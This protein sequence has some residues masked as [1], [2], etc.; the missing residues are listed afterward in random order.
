MNLV[1]EHRAA[2]VVFIL[3]TLFIDS[4]GFGLVIP[5]LPKLVEQLVGG[6]ISEASFAVGLL[7]SLYAVMQFFAAPLLGALSDRFGRRPVILL[8]LTSLGVDYVLLSLAPNLWWLVAGRIIAGIGGATITPAG[9]YIADVSPPDQRASNFGLMGVAFGLGF[10]AG[11]ALGGV[12]GDGNLRLPFVVAAGLSLLNVLFGLVVLPE[13]LAPENRRPLVLAQTNPLGAL[14]A[15]WRNPGVAAVMSVAAATGVAQMGLKSVWVLY[16]TYR[17][18]WSVADVGISLA[19]IGLLSIVVQGALVRPAVGR[20][21]EARTLVSALLVTSAS[22]VV[23]GLATQGWMMYAAT[24]GYC[25]GVGL[26]GPAMQGLLSRAVPADEQGLLQ[27]AVASVNTPAA[28][29]GPLLATGLF[30]YFVAPTAPVALPGAPFFMGGVL[31]LVSLALAARV[32]AARTVSRRV[33][34][35]PKDAAVA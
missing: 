26:L 14:Q 25:L 22:F 6:E 35:A 18:A 29:V 27:G 3:I 10:I 12:L 4:L 16:T 33:A 8:A 2:S 34:L 17:Y 28:I 24:A 19:V 20:F 32:A 15:V 1:R 13:S 5:I 9:A 23:F 31:C 21:G 11:P 30:G 7:T